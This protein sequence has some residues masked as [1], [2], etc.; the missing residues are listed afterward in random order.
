[1]LILYFVSFSLI[2]KEQVLCQNRIVICKRLE[3][4]DVHIRWKSRNMW[5]NVEYVEC[6]VDLFHIMAKGKDE[7]C[8]LVREGIKTAYIIEYRI[9]STCCIMS[10]D[11]Y[12]II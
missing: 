12:L 2:T 7:S 3:M 5:I 8:F 1:M 4:N 11:L 6:L 9:I 10:S